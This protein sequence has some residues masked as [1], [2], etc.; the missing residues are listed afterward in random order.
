VAGDAVGW[1]GQEL[2]ESPGDPPGA[3]EQE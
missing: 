3:P 1:P 2:P